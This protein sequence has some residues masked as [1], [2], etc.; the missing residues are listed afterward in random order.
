MLF[1]VLFLTGV[2]GFFFSG[3]PWGP[4]SRLNI[5]FGIIAALGFLLM[6]GCMVVSAQVRRQQKKAWL[7]TFSES[8]WERYVTA[9]EKKWD[10]LW[11]RRKS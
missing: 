1:I 8:E 2:F 6:I 4:L 10:R 7:N 3:S 5:V 9:P 11:W